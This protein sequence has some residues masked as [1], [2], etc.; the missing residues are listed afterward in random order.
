MRTALGMDS[1]DCLSASPAR[2]RRMLD[3][4]RDYHALAF[5]ICSNSNHHTIQLTRLTAT[6]M[7]L[8]LNKV[9]LYQANCIVPLY[10]T[11]H[12]C[13]NMIARWRKG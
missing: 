3:Y 2:A 12:A 1:K 13:S 9:Q 4:A 6:H 8:M 7:V 5:I 11:Q 10:A